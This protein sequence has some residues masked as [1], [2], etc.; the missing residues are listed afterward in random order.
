M[1]SCPPVVILE[2]ATPRSM[3]ALSA[4]FIA[5][6]LGLVWWAI[7]IIQ[8]RR[9]VLFS[10]GTRKVEGSRATIIGWTIIILVALCATAYFYS[11]ACTLAA[12]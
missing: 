11:I 7:R 2:D 6:Y 4:F 1:I 12:G 3:V 8:R 5:C 9:L 10:D